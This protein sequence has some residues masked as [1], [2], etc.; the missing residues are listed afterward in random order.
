MQVGTM[1]GGSLVLGDQ[2]GVLLSELGPL[3]PPAIGMEVDA[4]HLAARV[5]FDE[6]RES[7]AE[8]A[9]LADGLAEVPFG[10][11]AAT[12][13]GLALVS[14]KPVEVLPKL[15]HLEM[16]PTGNTSGQA[17]PFP[18]GHLPWGM[19][20]KQWG[21]NRD[22]SRI[23][24]HRRQRLIELLAAIECRYKEWFAA[25]ANLPSGG[26][27]TRLLYEEGAKG[28]KNIGDRTAQDI[29]GA[30]RLPPGWFDMPIGE[31]IPKG[32]KVLNSKGDVEIPEP[33]EVMDLDREMIG[34]FRAFSKLPRK[35][36]E[37]VVESLRSIAGLL[38]ADVVEQRKPQK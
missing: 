9:A 26:Y 32:I 6:R 13:E 11:A 12:G 25:A 18:R 37:H 30:F 21:M 20:P 34:Y 23:F 28:K 4:S 24:E 29:Q 14:G 8:F 15:L 33:E 7:G 17:I 5:R 2:L 16:V 36:R 1:S 38:D 35:K 27:L 19:P 3:D 31:A 10:R 22:L